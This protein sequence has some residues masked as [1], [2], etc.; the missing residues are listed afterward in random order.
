MIITVYLRIEFFYLYELKSDPTFICTCPLS[1]GKYNVPLVSQGG[2]TEEKVREQRIYW[3]I[4]SMKGKRKRQDWA[5]EAV[6]WSGGLINTSLPTWRKDC[7]L[8]PHLGG[9]G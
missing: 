3:R 8:E 9:N 1:P 2:D 7:L 6:R 4:A 5:G